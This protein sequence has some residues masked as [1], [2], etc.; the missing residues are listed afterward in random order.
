MKLLKE[1]ADVGLSAGGCFRGTKTNESV[2]LS[3]L[4]TKLTVQQYAKSLE[5][6]FVSVL[7]Q[8][9]DK[10]IPDGPL[11]PGTLHAVALGTGSLLGLYRQE[12][13][14]PAATEN[15]RFP[16]SANTPRPRRLSRS[17]LITSRQTSPG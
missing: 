13:S 1:I 15:W 16:A 8:G 2:S 10:L 3:V 14:L 12:R 17:L 11:N 5:E 4:I 9:G 6:N 7:E